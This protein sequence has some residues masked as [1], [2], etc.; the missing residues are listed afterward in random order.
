MKLVAYANSNET[1][2]GLG[3]AMR[4]L[5]VMQAWRKAGGE[6]R[7]MYQEIHP[8][9]TEQILAAGFVLGPYAAATP[10]AADWSVVDGPF[11][12]V[13][14]P[15]VRIQDD[16]DEYQGQIAP[17]DI[18]VN[19]NMCVDHMYA[20]SK[21]RTL[22]GLRYY[23]IRDL[24]TPVWSYGGTVADKAE[25]GHCGGGVAMWEAMA[26]GHVPTV[27]VVAE[28][29]RRNCEILHE[30]GAIQLEG[31][32]RGEAV[33]CPVDRRGADRIVA[34]MIDMPIESRPASR[35]D[36]GYIWSLRYSPAVH[37]YSSG[38]WHGYSEFSRY[39]AK[40]HPEYSILCTAR[41]RQA[42]YL[43]L[44]KA[45][46]VSIAIARKYR[47]LGFGQA[48]LASLKKGV[49]ASIHMDNYRSRRAF[50]AAGFVYEQNGEWVKK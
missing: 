8:K 38:P 31:E 48:V 30:M 29:Q 19:P 42:G 34:A 37:S 22:L 15:A 36:G 3:H 47:N 49:R 50:E 9:A 24:V 27:R 45:N 11:V 18:I 25:Q 21:H 20:G 2:L 33:P 6:A 1:N 39:F 5:A 14:G 10:H 26:H 40:R 16:P 46:F 44:D 43:R 28:D 32:A 4:A 7:F 35:A 12:D 23:P 13:P 41:G 17:K